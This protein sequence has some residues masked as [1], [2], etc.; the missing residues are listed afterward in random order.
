[1]KNE[2]RPS[3]GRVVRDGPVVLFDGVCHMCDE[4]VEFVLRHDRR[5]R[6]RFLSLQSA[7]ADTYLRQKGVEADTGE[8][9]TVVLIDGPQ[10]FVR[11]DAVL[12]VIAGLGF[13]WSL[14]WGLVLVPRWL[15]DP[16]YRWVARNR[17]RWFGRRE[18]CRIPTP[19]ERDRFL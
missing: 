3:P 5:G 14:L 16:M 2:Q 12:R 19:A 4:F 7:L 18:F 8:N 15:R 1:M 11:S 17:Y 13:P 10:T 6:F 9:G